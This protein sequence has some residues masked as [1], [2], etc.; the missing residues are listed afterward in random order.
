MNEMRFPVELFLGITIVLL[1]SLVFFP[2]CETIPEEDPEKEGD[3]VVKVEIPEDLRTKEIGTES[4]L[5]YVTLDRVEVTIEKDEEHSYAEEVSV[6][7]E[8][9]EIQVV[10][11]EIP[12]G[13]WQ[14]SVSAYDDE[15]Y[16]IA[17]GEEPATISYGKTTDV[18]IDME[19]TKADIEFKIHT[20][21]DDGVDSVKIEIKDKK[22]E[23]FDVTPG[24]IEDDIVIENIPTHIATIIVSLLDEEDKELGEAIAEDGIKL[25]PGRTYEAEIEFDDPQLIIS[26][27]WNLPPEKPEGVKTEFVDGKTEVEW[28]PA[29]RADGYRVFRSKEEEGPR[30]LITWDKVSD[31]FY[32]DGTVE[33]GKDYYYSVVAYTE[34][35]VS[36]TFSSSSKTS[37]GGNYAGWGDGA[38]KTYDTEIF[39][40]IDG[41]ICCDLEGTVDEQFLLK[42]IEDEKKVYTKKIWEFLSGIQ[43]GEESEWEF[44][45]DYEVTE[46][47]N[48]FFRNEES[49]LEK[50]ISEG[51]EVKFRALESFQVVKAQEVQQIEVPAGVF[52]EAWYLTFYEEIKEEEIDA[53]L[54]MK[55][56]FVPYIGVVKYEYIA[57]GVEKGEEIEGEWIEILKEFSF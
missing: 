34:E 47:G 11:S 8:E 46:E 49:F 39:I 6:D 31:N 38:E 27:S 56:W 36:S 3:L 23:K 15:D 35:G 18:I 32:K 14:V 13:D 7:G 41:D 57:Q 37:A 19:I 52:E 22:T 20:P 53:E 10:F 9:E 28:E 40:K 16:Q 54:E 29:V 2:G 42:E 48:N 50:P 5:E 24:E 45:M 55:L 26:A 25:L 33:F 30:K 1:T 12:A 4:M 43:E 44:E 21:D 17:L 51:D